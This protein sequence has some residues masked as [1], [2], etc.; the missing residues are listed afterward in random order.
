MIEDKHDLRIS[1]FKSFFF[2]KQ[3][4]QAI[5]NKSEIGTDANGIVSNLKRYPRQNQII[6]L[7]LS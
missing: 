2:W 1:V 6:G 3:Q 5:I 4:K 7:L